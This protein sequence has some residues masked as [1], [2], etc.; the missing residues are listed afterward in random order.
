[1]I[2]IFVIR[3]AKKVVTGSQNTVGDQEILNYTRG[4]SMVQYEGPRSRRDFSLR[5]SIGGRKE[6]KSV[7]GFWPDRRHPG[8]NAARGAP[9]P[10]L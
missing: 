9:R 8:R 7:R 10:R 5:D 1:M 6:D 4:R 3:S 2:Q